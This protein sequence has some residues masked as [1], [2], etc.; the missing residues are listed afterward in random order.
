MG[1][2]PKETFLKNTLKKYLITWSLEL[3]SAE[4]NKIS[5]HPE[6]LDKGLKY[7]KNTTRKN[8][9]SIYRI[10]SLEE[11]SRFVR[12][13][14]LSSTQSVHPHGIAIA[15]ATSIEEARKMVDLLVE[16]LGYGFGSVPVKNFLEYDI[17][18]LVQ[19]NSG[20]KQ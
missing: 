8:P 17:K 11:I 13:T 20:G 7:I 19:L 6:V 1:E 16:G 5:Q 9:I 4:L 2:K 3:G 15:E 12:S 10:G 18:P 14:R